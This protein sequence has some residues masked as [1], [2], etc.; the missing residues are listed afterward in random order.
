MNIESFCQS[1]QIGNQCIVVE[2]LLTIGHNNQT[3][4]EELGTLILGYTSE[5]TNS[6]DFTGVIP[7]GTKY[8]SSPFGLSIQGDNLEQMDFDGVNIFQNRT[9]RFLNDFF[10]QED[11]NIQVTQVKLKLQVLNDVDQSVSIRQIH[12][13]QT[14]SKADN[15]Q[16]GH[17]FINNTNAKLS[18]LNVIIYVKAKYQSPPEIDL[19]ASNWRVFNEANTSYVELLNNAQCF[20]G[21]ILYATPYHHDHQL[22]LEGSID[23]PRVFNFDY[24]YL[25]AGILVFFLI[26]GSIYFCCFRKKKR[27][28]I[29]SSLRNLRELVKDKSRR[30]LRNVM[31]LA[32][33]SIRKKKGISRFRTSIVSK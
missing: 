14:I 18:M 16:P 25:Y 19:N 10:I 33:I 23:N 28:T 1:I 31:H 2:S 9:G 15:L 17:D 32:H 13:N 30:S 6:L 7:T 20:S 21:P 26:L 24:R 27:N 5:I 22:I 4:E 29:R 12:S 8:S 11:L 3:T